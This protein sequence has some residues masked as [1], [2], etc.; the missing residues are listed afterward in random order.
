MDVITK[1]FGKNLKNLRKLKNYTQ[2][3]LAEKV[4]INLRQLARIESGES[5]ISSD[6]LYNICVALKIEPKMLFD[7]DINNNDLNKKQEK[8]PL[9]VDTCIDFN[10][11]KNNLDKISNDKAKLEFM[12]LAFNSLNS[13]KALKEL[14][15]VIKGIELILN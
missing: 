6:T 9:S 3:K 15:T 4:G 1:M 7:F 8:D 10:T 14:K 13:K 12:N 5:F 2:E 11:L